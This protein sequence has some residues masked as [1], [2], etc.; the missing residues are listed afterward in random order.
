MAFHARYSWQTFDA[1]RADQAAA[2]AG[3]RLARQTSETERQEAGD[4]VL[5]PA[6]ALETL[7]RGFGD[8]A[9]PSPLTFELTSRG[10]KCFVGVQEFTS[11]DGVIT[12]P[13]AVIDAL[14]LRQD[15]PLAAQLEE[16]IAVRYVALP[17]AR[18]VTI[19]PLTADFLDIHDH[20]SFLENGLR[21]S[22]TVLFAGQVRGRLGLCGLEGAVEA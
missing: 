16:K 12:V 17:K 1:F 22:F 13:Q 3:P 7:M 9:V 19:Q 5:M 14:N 21:S 6:Q 20:R 18:K 11:P 15:L 2:G 4:R 10:S 8:D